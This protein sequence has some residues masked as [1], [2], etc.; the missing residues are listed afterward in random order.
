[1]RLQPGL[2]PGPHWRS[3]QCSPD[4]VAG[5]GE[6]KKGEGKGKKRKGEGEGKGRDGKKEENKGGEKRGWQGR[7]RAPETAYCKDIVL[8]I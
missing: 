4:T 1:M 3:S 6:V 5:F 7:G 2:R 8:Y